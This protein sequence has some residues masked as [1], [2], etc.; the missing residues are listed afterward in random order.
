MN[1]WIV[2]D[3]RV[4]YTEHDRGGR[5]WWT[6]HR[7]SRTGPVDILTESPG[8][9]VVRLPYETEAIAHMWARTMVNV[10]VPRKALTIGGRP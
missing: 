5:H 9:D 3:E 2:V 4:I 8:G 10:G 7:A 1:A 6:A